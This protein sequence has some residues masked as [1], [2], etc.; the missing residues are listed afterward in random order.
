VLGS[1]PG[2]VTGRMCLSVR[3]RERHARAH[4][5]NRYISGQTDDPAAIGDPVSSSAAFDA[6]NALSLIDSYEGRPPHV[7]RV[8][9]SLHLARGE[10]AADLRGVRA[11]R[12]V[13]PG[14]RIRL[15]IA[16]QHVQDGRSTRTVRVKLPRGLRPGHRL[17]VLSGDRNK[18]QLEQLLELLLGGGGGT[19]GPATLPELVAEIDA[20]GG[21]DGVVGKL[22]GRTFRVFR[23]P[24]ELVTGRAI[25]P[26][27][28][29]RR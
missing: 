16:L 23:D 9:A 27:R 19:S 20:T 26:V 29:A 22:A 11:P 24:H 3:F 13:H 8:D 6:V 1:S 15:R 17:L 7:Q 2:R 28:V 12:V 21:Y 18:G 5:C 25:A 4:F 10:L 14:E